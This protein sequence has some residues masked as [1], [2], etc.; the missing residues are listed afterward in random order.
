MRKASALLGGI[1]CIALLLPFSA[2]AATRV[3]KWTGDDGVVHYTAEPPPAGAKQSSVMIVHSGA[4]FDE[5]A[6]GAASGNTGGTANQSS[7]V[8]AASDNKTMEANRKLCPG[9]KKDLEILSSGV[10]LNSVDDN[11]ET[12]VMNDSDRAEHIKQ[13]QEQINLFCQ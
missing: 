5:P 7:P 10:R 11:G 3:Y 12:H 2:E 1:C 6:P 8:Q 9:W 4:A 13:D